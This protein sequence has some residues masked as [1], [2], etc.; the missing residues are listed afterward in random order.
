MD[1]PRAFA[2]S[3]I[4]KI[5]GT[6]IGERTRLFLHGA[7]WTVVGAVLARAL[8]GGATLWAARCMGPSKFGE[9]S[10]ALAASLWLQIPMLAGIPTALLHYLPPL[11]LDERRRWAAVGLG[12]MLACSTLTLALAILFQ[13]TLR[14]WLGVAPH[15]FNWTLYWCAGY[16]LY[17]ASVSWVSA[18]EKFSTRAVME[19]AFAAM[20]LSLVAT[21]RFFQQLNASNYMK[22]YCV[23]YGLIGVLGF[24]LRRHRIAFAHHGGEIRHRVN[25]FVSYGLIVSLGGVASALLLAPAR[26]MAHHFL[27]SNEVGFLAVYQGGSIQIASILSSIIAQVFFPIASRTPNKHVLRRKMNQIIWMTMVPCFVVIVGLLAVYFKLLGKRYPFDL[28]SAMVYSF[29]AYLSCVFGVLCWYFASMGRRGL[30]VQCLISLAAGGVNFAGC[31]LLIPRYHIVGAG[32]A[33]AMGT[34]VGIALL[35]LPAANRMSGLNEP[36]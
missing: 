26:L 10:L 33:Y 9:A 11:G 34:L 7:A 30:L 31:R 8:S 6:G 35:F 13:D 3:T 22:S 4:T 19:I 23:A 27:D 12:I 25:R 29:S 28:T 32:W 24:I 17:T 16:T 2:K 1:L 15:V 36:L 20:L 14:T 5:T 18:E 21:A